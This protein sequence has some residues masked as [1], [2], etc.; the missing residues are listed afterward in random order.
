MNFQISLKKRSVLESRLC[1]FLLK[2]QNWLSFISDPQ[3]L[4]K[5]PFSEEKKSHWVG[6]TKLQSVPSKSFVPVRT[7]SAEK[8]L[9]NIEAEET[10]SRSSGSTWNQIFHISSPKFPPKK[11]WKK[12]TACDMKFSDHR[13]LIPSKI[14]WHAFQ[15]LLDAIIVKV[16]QKVEASF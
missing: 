15:K 14:A 1:W 3:L 8:P 13:L 9:R 7:M 11:D 12:P 16:G 6:Q 10:D 5:T 2:L 4:S